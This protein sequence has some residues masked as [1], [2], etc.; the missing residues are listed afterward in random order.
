MSLKRFVNAICYIQCLTDCIL[1]SPTIK[2]D[3]KILIDNSVRWIQGS[4]IPGNP[5]NELEPVR[6]AV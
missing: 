3:P 5:V 4:I 1:S 2:R 6:K